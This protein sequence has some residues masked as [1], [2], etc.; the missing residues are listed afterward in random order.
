VHLFDFARTIYGEHVQV[1]FRK[2][3]RDERRFESFEA[4]RRQ[5]MLDAAQARAFF[6]ID[7]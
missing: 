7:K 1:E 3:L 5:I 6:G 2:R 4:L